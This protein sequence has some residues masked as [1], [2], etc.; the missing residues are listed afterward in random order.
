LTGALNIFS[1]VDADPTGLSV[2]QLCGTPTTVTCHTAWLCS[3]E[4]H[5]TIGWDWHVLT[6]ER[7]VNWQREELPRINIQLLSEEG[8]ALEWE[9]SLRVMATWGMPTLGK[10]TWR[11]R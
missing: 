8:H 1:A 11:G 10:R 7:S 6:T 9:D 2:E 4:F 3:A 5:I